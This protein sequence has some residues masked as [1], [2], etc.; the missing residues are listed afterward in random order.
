MTTSTETLAALLKSGACN[1]RLREAVEEIRGSRKARFATEGMENYLKELVR[2]THLSDYAQSFRSITQA[3][4]E[5]GRTASQALTD[6]T[7]CEPR[8]PNSP[9]YREFKRHKFVVFNSLWPLT[10]ERPRAGDI[11]GPHGTLGLEA[12]VLETGRNAMGQERAAITLAIRISKSRND[13]ALIE[14]ANTGHHH[15]YTCVL[16]GHKFRNPRTAVEHLLGMTTVKGCTLST[17]ERCSVGQALG[18]PK[19]EDRLASHLGSLGD[20]LSD[21]ARLLKKS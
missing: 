9:I 4:L 19:N 1:S 12:I 18:Y 15:G 6:I 14:F 16:W 7:A 5:L 20:Y 2:D 11:F 13:F 8:T 17:S 21:V 10:R 3:M